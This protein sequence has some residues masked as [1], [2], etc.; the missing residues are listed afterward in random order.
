MGKR[1]QNTVEYVLLV[2]AVMLVMIPFLAPN[3]P[4]H[5]K[6]GKVG[7]SIVNKIDEATSSINF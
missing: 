7:D 1:G 5:T 3:G 4:F 2:V 6:V